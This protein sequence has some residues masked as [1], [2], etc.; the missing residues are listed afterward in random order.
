MAENKKSFIAYADW[1]DIFEELEDDEAG[2]LAKHLWRYVNDLNPSTDDRMV[3][4]SFTTIRN[5]LKRD[6]LKYKNIIDRNRENG[7]KGGRP[8]KPSGLIGNP[9]E[10]K[11][12]DS[13]NDNVSDSV[14]E[15]VSVSANVNEEK[16]NKTL[17][18]QVDE[19]TLDHR[20]KEYYQIAN[21]FMELF[22]SNLLELNISTKT[23]DSAKFKTWIN[24]IRLLME[25]DNRTIEEFREVFEFIKNDNFWK[26][27]IRS[28]EKLRKKD[29]DG[30]TY[31]EVLLIK[32]RNEQKR[33]SVSEESNSGVT[34]AYKRSI[35]N[36]LHGVKSDEKM[37]EN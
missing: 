7:K 34:E 37:P 27:Q 3:K 15:S 28:T 32:S 5:T 19:S 24:P 4:V 16:K 23:L 9:N 21:S 36:R 14:N 11:K 35:Y 12:A 31:F 10:P 26:Q 25:N 20:D 17:L 1:I 30:V 33:K 6:L 2:R 13:D 29:K 18:S 22:K 8:K